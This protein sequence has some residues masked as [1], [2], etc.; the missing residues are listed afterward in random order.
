MYKFAMSG[1]KLI[2]SASLCVICA[3]SYNQI[4]N[5]LQDM[6]LSEQLTTNEINSTE[7]SMQSIHTKRSTLRNWINGRHLRIATLEDFPLSYTQI[8]ENGKRIGSGVSFEVIDFLQEKF[9]FTYE[10][11]VPDANIIGSSND[12]NLSLIKMLNRSEVDLAAAFLPL[13]SDQRSY[14]YFSTTTLDEG[15]WIMVMR[16]PRESATGSGLMA[17]F[18]FWV[19][20]LIV[21]SLLF[22]GPIIY[23]F[24]ILRNKITKDS[25]QKPYSLGHCAWFV[26]GALMKQGSTLSPIAGTQRLAPINVC[27]ASKEATPETCR[28]FNSHLD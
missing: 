16:R 21:L 26:Y 17:P 28:L 2:L 11:V 20:I 14:I 19:W 25:D 4:Y 15:E 23:F 9:N 1:L 5:E 18:E 3:Q 8:L 13:L 10:V 6:Q 22:V 7:D 27:C 12:F 24:I